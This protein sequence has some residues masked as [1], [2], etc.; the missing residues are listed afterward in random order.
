MIVSTMH[1]SEKISVL[2]HFTP[3]VDFSLSLSLT[4]HKEMYK[5]WC[6]NYYVEIMR[7]ILPRF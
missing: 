3:G 1:I 4:F 5:I 7:K 6:K 2:D